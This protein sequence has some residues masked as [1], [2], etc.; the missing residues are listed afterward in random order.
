MIRM[1]LQTT[2]STYQHIKIKEYYWYSVLPL[3]SKTRHHDF[4]PTL[5]CPASL[6]PGPT[7]TSAYSLLPGYRLGS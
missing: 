7:S 6:S 2:Y 4:N 3:L 5:R 1:R